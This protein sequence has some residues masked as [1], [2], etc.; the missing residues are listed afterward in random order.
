MPHIGVLNRGLLV[1]L[2]NFLVII[3][4]LIWGILPVEVKVSYINFKY[5]INS[6]KDITPRLLYFFPTGSF[7]RWKHTDYKIF[8]DSGLKIN[9][10]IVWHLCIQICGSTTYWN[11]C[12]SWR[13]GP[14]LYSSCFAGLL[15]LCLVHCLPSICLPIRRTNK[16][17]YFYL[18]EW[19]II[20]TE[21]GN[22]SISFS[23]SWHWKIMEMHKG[24]ITKVI[25]RK[26]LPNLKG[27]GSFKGGKQAGW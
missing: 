23:R 13:A 21:P 8:G 7:Q 26:I 11:C 4:N 15:A 27:V 2:Q 22:Q 12:A 17:I 18:K 1:S 20:C 24:Q 16:C 14:E 9:T 6:W 5:L 19:G 25:V 10:Y 3:L